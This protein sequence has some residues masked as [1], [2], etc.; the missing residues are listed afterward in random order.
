MGRFINR[1]ILRYQYIIIKIDHIFCLLLLVVGANCSGQTSLSYFNLSDSLYF[2]PTKSLYYANKAIPLLKAEK[3]TSRYLYMLNSKSYL[4]QTLEQYDSMAIN[5][6]FALDEADRLVTPQNVAYQSAL[7]NLARV[8]QIQDDSQSAIALYKSALRNV[9]HKNIDNANL[10][11]TVYENLGL[12]FKERGDW[13]T[14]LEFLNQALSFHNRHK[15]NKRGDQA[16]PKVAK[17]FQFVGQVNLELEEHKQ[18]EVHLMK[19]EKEF[20]NIDQTNSSFLSYVYR[21]F[22]KLYT[23]ERSFDKAEQYALR[24]LTLQGLQDQEKASILESFGDLRIQQG[25][26]EDG[27]KL[28]TECQSMLS[29]KVIIKRSELN[30]KIAEA[31]AYLGDTNKASVYTEEAQHLLNAKA[32]LNSTQSGAKSTEFYN[33][34]ELSLLFRDLAK[35]KL[36]QYQKEKNAE[37]LLEALQQYDN[38]NLAI[39]ALIDSYYAEE[40]KWRFLDQVKSYYAEALT[41][42][43]N[44][45]DYQPDVAIQYATSFINSSKSILLR[46]EMETRQANPNYSI[47]R[48]ELQQRIRSVRSYLSLIDQNEEQKKKYGSELFD[49]RQQ[50]IE[51]SENAE[52]KLPLSNI[53]TPVLIECPEVLSLNYFIS[54]SVGYIVYKNGDESSGLTRFNPDNSIAA[55]K[56]VVA[57]INTSLLSNSPDEQLSMLYSDLIPI[58]LVHS[59][60][61]TIEINPDAWLSSFSFDILTDPSGDYLLTN[62]SI[63]YLHTEHRNEDK[64]SPTFSKGTLIQ[65]PLSELDKT[66]YDMEYELLEPFFTDSY[67]ADQVSRT[68][69]YN[70]LENS[71]ILH[72]ST[73]AS[74]DSIDFEP[75]IRVGDDLIYLR[76]IAALDLKNEL[77]V[78]SA[79]ETELGDYIPGEGLNS[80]SRSFSYAGAKSIL[81]SLWQV[82]EQSTLSILS[83]FYTNLKQGQSKSLALRNAKL[84]Y[85]KTAPDHKRHPYYWAGLILIGDDS[86][87]EMGGDSYVGTILGI[88]AMLIFCF[89]LW[90]K[91][92]S[93]INLHSKEN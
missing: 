4:F 91:S 25:K 63:K 81:S 53:D 88:T 36:A 58:D 67:R 37:Y 29:D 20:M 41:A 50:L 61:L 93:S 43:Y 18:A 39:Y 22:V 42:A 92:P 26:Y 79:C 1:N 69:L 72:L 8:Y 51:L 47:E 31:Y 32:F 84:S 73:H 87:I 77:V 80:L 9:D 70:S 17:V 28:Y 23:S 30:R 54:D 24:G 12:I 86:P 71:D 56:T 2:K 59:S 49:L 78:L 57:C 38:M 45:S 89:L 11:G 16:H 64:T 48:K 35:L 46:L 10:V 83:N 76:D 65:L 82:N 60:I 13:Y 19:S 68:M 21:D 15:R 7:N 55:F 66:S 3:D 40:S 52:Q 75:S 14:S 74:Y 62:Y 85:I 34:Q 6:R 44:Y 33:H 90:K 5:N 27:L